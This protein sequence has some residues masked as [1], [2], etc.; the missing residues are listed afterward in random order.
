MRAVG[1]SFLATAFF[2]FEKFEN[3]KSKFENFFFA[4]DFFVLFFQSSCA[5]CSAFLVGVSLFAYKSKC[6]KTVFEAEKKTR[7]T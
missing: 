1:S 4:C 3:P 7:Q 2:K 5:F 6:E